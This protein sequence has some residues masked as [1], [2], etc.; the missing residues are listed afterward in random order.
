M[1]EDWD[2]DALWDLLGKARPVPVSPFFSR[3]ILREIRRDSARPLVQ[4][5]LLRWLGAG[6]LAVLAVGFF[7]NL[8]DPG[9]GS[10]LT[11]S[12]DFVETFDAAA[13][14]DTLVAVEDVSI[15]NDTADL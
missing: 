10:H 4:P 9:T 13:G 11:K 5:F 14:L 2:K 8:D 15:F 3:N 12:A 1:N 7:L 6:A